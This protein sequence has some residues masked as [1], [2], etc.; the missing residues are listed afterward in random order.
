[1]YQYYDSKNSKGTYPSENYF[2]LS[3]G[4]GSGGVREVFPEGSMG[5]IPQT[6]SNELNIINSEKSANRVTGDHDKAYKSGKE[7]SLEEKHADKISDINF[8]VKQHE[9]FIDY[10]DAQS[11]DPFN[12][13]NNE[14]KIDFNLTKKLEDEEQPQTKVKPSEEYGQN[15]QIPTIQKPDEPN[16]EYNPNDTLPSDLNYTHSEM[17]SPEMSHFRDLNDKNVL[18]NDPDS[19]H[20]MSTS[21]SNEIVSPVSS[22]IGIPASNQEI[23]KIPHQNPKFHKHN[24]D[25][26]IRSDLYSDGL[27]Q[28]ISNPTISTNFIRPKLDPKKNA[29]ISDSL[30]LSQLNFQSIENTILHNPLI[31]GK[32]EN[33]IS[34]IK[35]AKVLKSEKPSI[36]QRQQFFDRLL[37]EEIEKEYIKPNKTISEKVIPRIVNFG[38]N[39]S[40]QVIPSLQSPRETLFDSLSGKNNE[41]AVLIPNK[42]MDKR[43]PGIVCSLVDNIQ[44]PEFISLAKIDFRRLGDVLSPIINLKRINPFHG[45][46]NKKR[47]N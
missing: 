38:K 7:L 8:S 16:S 31:Q 36:I 43:F 23:P 22:D 32:L 41:N 20:N 12:E 14:E 33:L 26:D 5:N 25:L 21:S 4:A 9:D 29:M 6:K 10:G 27:S 47:V 42:Y 40:E 34:S 35:Q 2:D 15:N 18:K 39:K 17:Q 13:D 28:N 30:P 11:T 3:S 1:M 44:D 19:V 37:I 46:F 45:I 24:R